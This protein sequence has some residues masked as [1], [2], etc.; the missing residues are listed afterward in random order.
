MIDNLISNEILAPR[1]QLAEPSSPG[2]SSRSASAGKRPLA[3][4][5]RAWRE[6]QARAKHLGGQ[7][8]ETSWLGSKV[9]HR[10]LCPAGHVATPSPNSVQRGN[11]LCRACAGKDP[12][13][14]WCEFQARVTALGGRV[15][16]PHW[17]GA[18]TPHR[19]ECAAG[20]P[21]S[22]RP[23]NVQQ[24]GGLCLI[25]VGHD[26]ATAWW[27]FQV[28]VEELG[29]SV[30]ELDWLGNGVPHRVKCSSGHEVSPRPACVQQG[31]GI[32][33]ICAGKDPETAWKNFCE[34]VTKL[35][36]AVLESEWLGA[37]TPHWVRCAH[38]HEVNPRP[39]GVQQGQGIC[40]VC[41]GNDPATAERAFRVRVKELGGTVLEPVWLGAGIP[42]QVRCKVGH[43][44]DPI[45]S[46]VRYGSGL[47]RQC[48]G[49]IWDVFYVVTNATENTL[50]F[51]ITSGKP[52]P[53]LNVH[54]SEG[55]RIAV[56]VLINL[57]DGMALGMER[58][59]R[60]ALLRAG[61]APAR[62][63]EYFDLSALPV[64]LDIVDNIPVY[65]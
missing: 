54:A 43:L 48:V 18:R 59:V 62:G 40:R 26:P 19:A 61:H 24:G 23:N 13:I 64:V 42:H 14:A 4:S 8:L 58:G 15:L 50:K 41:A 17:L 65:R 36:G 49:L 11:G 32:C 39:A 7:L 30:L 28:R 12:E 6:F 27:Q 57:P 2:G 63:R 16:E 5:E 53:R 55:F 51:G 56:R 45:P 3:R 47:C 9:S 60:S 20:H 31:K 21:T 10:V 22:P 1:T 35:G 34:Q 38:G 52:R 44:C 33:R 29:G 46:N 25:C 37:L